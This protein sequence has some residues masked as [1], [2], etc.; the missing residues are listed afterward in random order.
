MFAYVCRF[1]APN[2]KCGPPILED[3]LWPFTFIFNY[4]VYWNISFSW[5]VDIRHKRGS[6]IFCCLRTLY[7]LRVE[8]WG[9]HL[10]KWSLLLFRSS[11][12]YLISSAWEQYKL[13]QVVNSD[14]ISGWL[15]QRK[16][17]WKK[18]NLKIL[19]EIYVIEALTKL[20]YMLLKLLRRS[21][22]VFI[23]GYSYPYTYPLSSA[24]P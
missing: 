11:K 4:F 15:C 12:F 10:A 17:K 8:F 6:V 14:L 22:D 23:A 19:K 9:Y 18:S 24:S 5:A 21:N 2:V 3:C 20:L 7:I 13:T 1:I 16:L